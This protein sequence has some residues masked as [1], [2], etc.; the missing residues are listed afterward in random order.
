MKVPYLKSRID[1]EFQGYLREF[2]DSVA[3]RVAASASEGGFFRSTFPLFVLLRGL[4]NPNYAR[5]RT[6]DTVLAEL[7]REGRK[8]DFMQAIAY[9]NSRQPYLK[10]FR[11]GAQRSTFAGY[12]AELFSDTL[13]L[14]NSYYSCNYRGAFIALRCML[15]DLY[16]HLYFLD[17]PQE[18]WR[19]V[20]DGESPPDHGLSPAALREYLKTTQYLAPFKVLT[21][22][23]QEK[24]SSSDTDIFGV[25]ESL[26]SKCSQSV[27][28]S[29]WSE[30]NG[31]RSNGDLLFDA[32]RAKDV[33]QA[34]GQFVELAIAMLCAAHVDCFLALDEYERSLVLSAYDGTKRASLRRVLNV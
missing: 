10:E 21:S 17:H 27:H 22:D 7:Q 34:C 12:F 11:S 31:F 6:R 19:V 23:F 2:G 15:E 20:G 14:L 3:A 28:A 26:Y 13:L 24:A 4:S 32:A 1:K 9:F 5:N 33:G 8:G 16:R 29:S 25:N 18:F 30:M